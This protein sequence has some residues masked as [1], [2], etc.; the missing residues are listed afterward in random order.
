[1][2][3]RGPFDGVILILILVLVQPPGIQVLFLLFLLFD[4]L[5]PCGFLGLVL[6]TFLGG[7]LL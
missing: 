1:M 6:D 7:R 5:G 2:L 4:L 3:E